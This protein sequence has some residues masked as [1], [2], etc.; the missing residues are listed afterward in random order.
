MRLH[1]LDDTK[2]AA[3]RAHGGRIGSG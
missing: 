2:L 3:I 1:D